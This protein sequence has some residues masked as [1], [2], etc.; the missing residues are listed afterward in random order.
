MSEVVSHPDDSARLSVSMASS[1]SVRLF[2]VA[3]SK[4][5]IDVIA[6]IIHAKTCDDVA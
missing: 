1:A 3:V 6:I 5:N 4:S 2:V